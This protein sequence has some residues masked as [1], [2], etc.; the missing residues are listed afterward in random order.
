MRVW[1]ILDV[2]FTIVSGLDP[3]RSVSILQQSYQIKWDFHCSRLISRF[4][5]QD[6]AASA[7]VLHVCIFTPSIA[8]LFEQREGNRQLG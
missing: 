1:P 6:L 8:A 5:I 7:G 2:F 4:Q 3:H